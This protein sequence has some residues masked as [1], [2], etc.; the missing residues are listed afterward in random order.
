CPRCHPWIR[1]SIT[2]SRLVITCRHPVISRRGGELFC[3]LTVLLPVSSGTLL[4]MAVCLQRSTLTRP[5][6]KT[7]PAHS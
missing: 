5:L 7:L 3:L 6:C 2:G 1:L 4:W